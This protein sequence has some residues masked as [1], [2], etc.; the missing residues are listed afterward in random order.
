MGIAESV[1]NVSI[2]DG[3]PVSGFWAWLVQYA[4]ATALSSLSGVRAF[5]PAFILSVAAWSSSELVHLDENME[6]IQAARHPMQHSHD[7]GGSGRRSAAAM[8]Y[9]IDDMQQRIQSAPRAN[10]SVR[11]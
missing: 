7:G 11:S 6:W 5:L 9:R 8:R 3:L 4:L 1:L 2:V 10:K